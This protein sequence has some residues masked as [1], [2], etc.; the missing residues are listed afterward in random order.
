VQTL[1]RSGWLHRKEKAA[2]SDARSSTAGQAVPFKLYESYPGHRQR[3]YAFIDKIKQAGVAAGCMGFSG[4]DSSEF[5]NELND[6]N[7]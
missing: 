5:L 7:R 4:K 1:N 3:L 2:W 6:V